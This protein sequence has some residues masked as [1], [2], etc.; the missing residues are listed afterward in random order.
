MVA[1]LH[2]DI[3]AEFIDYMAPAL[4]GRPEAYAT[5]VAVR[6]RVP[7][8][9]STQAWPSSGRLVVVRDDGGPMTQD[10][11]ATARLGVRVW[12]PTEAETSDL[13][14]LVVALVRGWRSPVVRR[15]EPTRPYSVTEESRRPAMYFTA[16][17]MIRGRALPAA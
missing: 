17:L 16:E 9:S 14:N 5:D 4:D 7:N 10:V 13:A 1:I 12:A 11:R 6:N 2:A 3:E 15:T 8:E